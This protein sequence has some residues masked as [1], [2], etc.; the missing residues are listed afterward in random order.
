MYQQ[1]D[2]SELTRSLSSFVRPGEVFEIRLLHAA[3]KRTDSGYFD[4][5]PEAAAA[6]AAL[7]EPY[8]GIYFTPNPVVPDLAARSYNR[9]SPW[10]QLTTMDGDI[11]ERRWLLIDIDAIRPKG[12]SS[13]DAE[14]EH[15]FK[16]AQAIANM[17][18]LSGWPRPFINTSGNGCHVMYAI[19][20]P[21]TEF[22]RDEIALFLKCLN[23]RFKDDGAEIDTVNFNAARIWRVPGTWARKGDNIPA[24][25]HRKAG[26]VNEPGT[27]ELVTFAQIHAFNERNQHLLPQKAV[28]LASPS[29]SSSD[30]HDEKKY[31]SVN[32][33]A[34]NRMAEWVPVF[35]PDAYEY[36]QGYRVKSEDIGMDWE[37]DL[38]LH[39]WPLGIKYFGVADQGDVAEGRRTPVGVIADFVT[40]GDKEL[41]A[42]KLADTL[43][44]PLTEFTDIT[45]PVGLDTSTLPGTGSTRP[46]FDF[47]RVPSI[48]DLQ[49]RQFKKLT[50]IVD[51]V[52]PTGNFLLAARPKMRKTFLALQLGIAITSGRKFLGNVC[53]K[54]DVLFLG[55]EDNERR[56]RSRID[57]LQTL[58]LNP[59]DLSGFRYWT[60]GVDISP[61]GKTFI[62]D[63]EEHARTY[64]AF[65][66]GEDGV[67]ALKR[68]LDAYPNTRMI[69][70]DTYAHFRAQS[71]NRDVYQRDYDQMM[72]ITK[73]C[74]ERDILGIVVH[75]EKKGLAG[76]ATGDFLED[77]SGSTGITGA[78][79]GVIS[80]KGKRGPSDDN[81]PRQIFISG[82]D[83]PKDFV[84]DVAFDAER[85]GWLPATRQDAHASILEL[86]ARHPILSQTD[87]V[88]LLPGLS[89]GRIS[90]ICTQ[91][92]FEGALVKRRDGYTLKSM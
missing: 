25:P 74:A 26:I 48:A 38:T 91:L 69:V 35:F 40:K 76:T 61:S 49:R 65:P 62:S 84:F 54:G 67:D 68:F 43:K 89:R 46:M 78:V 82:R 52:L 72:P 9:I 71:N 27:V 88:N 58:D 7:N 19:K 23:A 70:I 4:S 33:H 92:V 44:V 81:E 20:E 18:E 51:N 32:T 57:L 85:G 41:A 21:N 39:P 55:L 34:M 15:T 64:A 13:T 73:L 17:L 86:L 10:A 2:Y 63:P 75:H 1:H 77:V 42:R 11:T 79:D 87:L 14:L 66:R 50:W 8:Q 59:P 45:P 90:Q 29:A 31:H 37:E 56:M 83:V 3:R 30:P 36:K 12:I 22:I 6:I 60:G 53:F 24:R 28:T 80:I 16:V 5:V 47:S